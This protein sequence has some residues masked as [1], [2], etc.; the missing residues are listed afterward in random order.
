M[1][2]LYYMSTY[3]KQMGDKD[4]DGSKD[5]AREIF[6]NLSDYMINKIKSILDIGFKKKVFTKQTIFKAIK[7]IISLIEEYEN[8]EYFPL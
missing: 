4:Y 1:V 7:N 6:G 2:R 3:Y 8:N 5:N